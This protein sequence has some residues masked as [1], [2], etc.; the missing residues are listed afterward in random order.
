MELSSS[1]ECRRHQVIEQEF[2]R[3]EP[4]LRKA[5]QNFVD[6]H[7]PEAVQ[8][9]TGPREFYVSF[10]N[11]PNKLALRDLRTECL[12]SLV[13]FTGTVTRSSEVGFWTLI[14]PGCSDGR[15]FA[16]ADHFFECGNPSLTGPARAFVRS[17]SLSRMQ[18]DYQKRR[19]AISVHKACHM[20]ERHL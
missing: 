5:V 12:G 14:I 9:E 16:I 15:D 1:I 10:F 2:F 8:D 7:K 19:T 3:Y 13:S 4:F 11:L 20:L 6:Q 18:H 17:V